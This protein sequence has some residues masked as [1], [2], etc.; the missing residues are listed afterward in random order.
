MIELIQL[1]Y[2]SFLLPF[3]KFLVWISP[4]AGVGA[5]FFALYKFWLSK[6]H[7]KRDVAAAVYYEILRADG[8]VTDYKNFK[9]YK[10]RRKIIANNSW[11]KNVQLFVRDFSVI[12]LTKISDTYSSGE[13]LDKLIERHALDLIDQNKY[14][15]NKFIEDALAEINELD[16]SA[17]KNSNTEQISKLVGPK[18]SILPLPPLSTATL[19]AVTAEYEFISTTPILTKLKQIACIQP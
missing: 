19:D 6:K 10:F 18:F 5:L 2:E 4:V 12:D 16:P 7:L 15:S 14:A 8:I 11:A 9:S 13:F 17:L 1:F 3:G